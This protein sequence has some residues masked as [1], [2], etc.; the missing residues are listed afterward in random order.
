MKVLF[1]MTGSWGTG[2]GTVVEA[3]SRELIERG[4]EV[5]VLCP[6]PQ[7]EEGAPDLQPPPGIRQALWQFP[8]KDAGVELYTFPLMIPDPNPSNLRNAWTFRDLSQNEL[9]LYISAFQK[10]FEEAVAEFAPDI[11][12][13]HHIWL[14][15]YAVAR[16]GHPYVCVAHHSDQMGFAFDE[17]IRPYATEAALN[18]EYIFAITDSNRDEVLDLYGVPEERVVVIPNGYDQDVF[19]PMEVDRPALL[20]AFDLSIPEG[21]TL[22]TFAGKLSRTK[23]IDVLLEAN[24][25]LQQQRNVHLVVFGTGELEDAMDPSDT[26]RYELKNVHFLGHQDYGVIARFHNLARFSVMPSRTEGFGIAA[27]EAMGCGKPIVTT[28]TGG[29]DVYGVGEVVET[30]DPE[31]MAAAMLRIIDLDEDAYGALCREALQAAR[32]YSWARIT[33]ERIGYYR[34]VR[35]RGREE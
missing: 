10:R 32:A 5:M 33:E 21:A 15:A 26:E 28:R 2:S 12:I 30:E 22:I 7:P 4:H 14:M 9:D 34:E 29:P 17:R 8:L 19:R 35:A 20:K 24:K 18:A 11:V 31:G 13:C 23:G 6:N 1:T 16:L 3:V 25:L 27:L